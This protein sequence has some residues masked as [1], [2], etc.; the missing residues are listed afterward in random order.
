MAPPHM[1][2]YGGCPAEVVRG[3]PSGKLRRRLLRHSAD[4]L[5]PIFKRN[6]TG[7]G[8]ARSVGCRFLQVAR[9][10]GLPRGSPTS[11]AL[12]RPAGPDATDLSLRRNPAAADICGNPATWR[13]KWSKARILPPVL[14]SRAIR[15]HRFLMAP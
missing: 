5:P 2:G 3:L 9:S 12:R 7:T 6:N 15:C 4:L 1:Q 13:A 8:P 10:T 14:A 11:G